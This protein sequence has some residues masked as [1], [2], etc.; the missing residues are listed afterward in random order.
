M[1]EWLTNCKVLST[2]K[3]T[4]YTLP[5]GGTVPEYKVAF[6]SLQWIKPI[7]HSGGCD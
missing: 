4:Q 1:K 7:A 6:Y 5:K 2:K 3:E